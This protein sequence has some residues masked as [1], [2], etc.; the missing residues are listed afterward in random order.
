MNVGDTLSA[1][2][3]LADVDLRSV[4]DL[5]EARLPVGVPTAEFRVGF[6]V[7]LLRILLSLVI[8]FPVDEQHHVRVLLDRPGVPEVLQLRPLVVAALHLTAQL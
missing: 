1:V 2:P 6:V 7:F 3:L 8:V 4:C 5:L